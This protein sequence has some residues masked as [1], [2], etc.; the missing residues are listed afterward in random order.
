MG[1]RRAVGGTNGEDHF[2]DG[3]AECDSG[4]A[5]RQSV[6]GE[7]SRAQRAQR[8]GLC[9]GHKADECAVSL[10][11]RRRFWRSTP[12]DVR[13]AEVL[14]EQALEIEPDDV[15]ALSTLAHC[16]LFTHGVALPFKL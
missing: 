11:N 5:F 7:R 2:R 6:R 4:I 14:L 16:K 9:R 12:E 8:R 15:S 1:L 13:A 3:F 10:S